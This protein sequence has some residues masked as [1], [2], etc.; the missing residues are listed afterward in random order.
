MD[1]ELPIETPLTRRECHDGLSR[2]DLFAWGNLFKEIASTLDNDDPQYVILGNCAVS[3]CRI[4]L[5]KI[6][7]RWVYVY[8]AKRSGKTT[9]EIKKVLSVSS[10]RVSELFGKVQVKIRYVEKTVGKATL[11]AFLDRYTEEIMRSLEEDIKTEELMQSMK[12]YIERGRRESL[13]N[14]ER[15]RAIDNLNVAEPPKPA[16]SFFYISDGYDAFER[17]NHQARS[18]SP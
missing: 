16:T 5:A 7:P 2:Q 18:P 9:K 11:D 4:R 1:I 12:E 8:V 17:F 6:S 3:E 15:W 13:R 10:G 14:I